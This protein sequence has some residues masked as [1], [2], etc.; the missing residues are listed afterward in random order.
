MTSARRFAGERL[1]PRSPLL[2]RLVQ[3]L[4]LRHYSDRTIETYLSWVLRY[5]RFHGKRHPRELG[6]DEVEEF[7]TSLA[8]HT[9]VSASTQNQALAAIGF[10]Y[11]DVLDQQLEDSERLTRA[12]RPVR[13][14]VVLTR[15]EVKRLI[16]EMDGVPQLATTL[17]YGTGMRV[18]EC[19]QL[20]VKDLDFGNHQIL[21]RGKGSKDRITMLPAASEKLLREHLEDVRVTHARDLRRGGGRVDLPGALTRKYPKASTEFRWQYI[22]PATRTHIDILTRELRRHHLHPT[23]IQ[24]AVAD[25]VRRAGLMKRATCHTFRHSFA[26]HLIE[27]GYD[28]RTIQE[29]L[30]HTDVRTTMIYTHVLNKGGRGV[31]SPIDAL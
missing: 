30:G 13:L 29:L 6:R 31:R 21:V 5:I 24:R 8:V 1:I 20:R 7:L 28:I 2:G 10:L 3:Q 14:P 16:G 17:L 15:D 19:L 23:V 22:F 26:T 25:A 12:K 9:N 27:D 4:R 18:M 11:R